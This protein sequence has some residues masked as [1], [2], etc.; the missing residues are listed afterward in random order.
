[1][2]SLLVAVVFCRCALYSDVSISPLVLTPAKIDRGADLQG[3]IRKADYLRAIELAPAIEGR[4][5]K[6]PADLV[7]L[8]EAE[9]AAGRFD[10][11]RRHL[12]AA[13]ELNPFRDT[14]ADAAWNLAQ[15]EYLSNNYAIAL[16]WTETAM[17]HGLNVMRWHVDYLRA[18]SGIQAYRFSG[19]PSDQL[20]MRIGRPDVPRID[21]RLN[22]SATPTSA[23]I[24]SGAVLS[25]ASQQL[26]TDIPIR[27]LPI[28]SGTFYGLLGE[29]I[30]VDFG[31]IDLLELGAVVVENVPV[32]IMP[33]DKMRFFVT[34][35]QEFKID[36]LLGANL[37]KEFRMEMKFSRDEV[38]FTRLSRLEQPDANQ[39]LFFEAFR[40]HVRATV[41]KRGWFLFVVD[42]GSEVTYLNETQLAALPISAFTPR[43]HTATLQGLGGARKS[44]AKVEDVEIGVD[45]W[46]GTF[47]TI[48]MYSADERERA[49][50]IVGENF[51]KNFDVVIDFGR[52]RVDLE[53]R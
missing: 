19:S 15:V 9:L 14:Y 16:E 8:G 46:A 52:M 44:G 3:M 11:A 22:R 33:S 53:R 17:R 51:L 41:N 50:G 42:T 48:P 43:V 35:H 30:A 23:V 36:L 12:R 49:V 32:A 40:P 20:P 47:R 1:M 31:I 26:A 5:R 2:L 10:D 6:N 29:P 13:I 25:I 45:R 39:N 18:L 34:G 28:P 37:L 21:V 24:D 7:A 4:T 38:V 27:R